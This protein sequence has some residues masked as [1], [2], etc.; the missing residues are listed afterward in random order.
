MAE[1]WLLRIAGGNGRDP[2]SGIPGQIVA[3]NRKIWYDKH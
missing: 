1:K 2:D 3:L